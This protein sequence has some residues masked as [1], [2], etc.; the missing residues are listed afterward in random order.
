MKSADT[1]QYEPTRPVRCR[2][3]LL[4]HVSREPTLTADI[5]RLVVSAVNVGSYVLAFSGIAKNVDDALSSLREIPCI[6]NNL[7]HLGDGPY[8][9]FCRQLPSLRRAKATEVISYPI[10]METVV[11]LRLLNVGLSGESFFHCF[12]IVRLATGLACS[13]SN[14]LQEL[15]SLLED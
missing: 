4:T 7:L 5:L 12:N 9:R 3:S 11:T 6:A 1:S 10:L 14:M 2:P 8:S 15:S 13:P